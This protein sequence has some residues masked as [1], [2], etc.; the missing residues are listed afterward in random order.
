[1]LRRESRAHGHA[2]YGVH[3]AADRIRALLV[4]CGYELAIDSPTNQV[5]VVL[6]GAQLAALSERVEMGFIENL[7]DGRTIMRFATSWATR[8]EDVDALGD[9]L[10]P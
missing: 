4:E 3:L 7:P 8:L 5:F 9:V 6:D 1:M 2:G 10:A